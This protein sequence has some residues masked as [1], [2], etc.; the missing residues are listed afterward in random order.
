MC[1][2]VFLSVSLSHYVSPCHAE[3]ALKKLQFFG[4]RLWKVLLNRF[5]GWYVNVPQ[6]TFG[7]M[8]PNL[9]QLSTRDPHRVDMKYPEFYLK[10]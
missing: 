4:R 9:Y 10:P 2:C 3:V 8:N 5:P 7:T 1:V 6:P